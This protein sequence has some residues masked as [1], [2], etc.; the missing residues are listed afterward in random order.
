MIKTLVFDIGGV[1]VNWAPVE[2]CKNFTSDEE[3]AKRLSKILFE[4]PEF[5][6][7]DIGKYTRAQTHEL[8]LK[9]YPELTDVINKAM[10]GCDEIL[11][12]SQ[13]NTQLLKEL[14]AAGFELYFLSNTNPSAFEWMQARHEFFKLMDGG[15]ASFKVKLMKPDHSIFECFLSTYGKKAEECVFVDDTPVNTKAA[16]ECGFGSIRN[17]NRIFKALS[18]QTPRDLQKAYLTT[19]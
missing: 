14:K 9:N 3:E 2:F 13:E 17:F 11:V 1:L 18:N 12:A 4:G 19:S 15:I 10:A 6:G 5:K 16:S 7:G 8:L